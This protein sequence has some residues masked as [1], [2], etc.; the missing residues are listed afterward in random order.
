M[1]T[2]HLGSAQKYLGCGEHEVPRTGEHGVPRISRAQSTWDGVS[3][4]YLG[5][6][7]HR[8]RDGVSTEFLGWGEHGAP[9]DRMSTEYLGMG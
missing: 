1:S 3:T 8:A 4:E 2:E 9:R 6:G 5:W 7:E